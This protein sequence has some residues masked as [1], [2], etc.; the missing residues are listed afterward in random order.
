MNTQEED[1]YGVYR[2]KWENFARFGILERVPI[3]L[4]MELNK[5]CNLHCNMCPFHS[6]HQVE[7]VEHMDI[8]TAC[9]IIDDFAEKGGSSIKFVYRGEPLL[10]KNL[11]NII[12][13]AKLK[14]IVDTIVNTNGMLLTGK[15]AKELI[16]C[17]LD[18]LVFS[19]DSH[20]P[21]IY[22]QIRR[23]GDLNTV[24]KNI[25]ALQSLKQFYGSK[26]PVV[27]IQGLVQYINQVEMNDGTFEAFWGEVADEILINPYCYHHDDL[28]PAD[29]TPFFRCDSVWL[30]L[31][32]RVNGDIAL[33]CGI[34]SD[35]K[36]L[37][38]INDDSIEDIWLG[39]NM[40]KI[41]KLI[42]SGKAH[43]ISACRDCA[44][45]RKDYG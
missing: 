19:I 36:I 21:E 9:K 44:V 12:G 40:N 35:D 2:W 6:D 32:V 22:R 24:Y 10:H 8:K 38:N 3:H 37:G 42:E 11:H 23:G 17:G 39:D 14:G 28:T 41:R 7:G 26:K 29:P 43:L 34:D 30:R 4:D 45:R 15:K 16:L 18:K 20:Q 33:C 25:V 31:T 13:Y 1:T 5:E 27:R